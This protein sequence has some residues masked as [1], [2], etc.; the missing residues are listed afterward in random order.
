MEACPRAA[1]HSSRRAAIFCSGALREGNMTRS[2]EPERELDAESLDSWRGI[3]LTTGKSLL[4]LA[5][6][7]IRSFH[8]LPSWD[9]RNPNRIHAVFAR[10]SRALHAWNVTRSKFRHICG[11]HRTRNRHSAKH[12]SNHNVQQRIVCANSVDNRKCI[13]SN[14]Y[15]R[16][17]D[18]KSA[19]RSDTLCLTLLNRFYFMNSTFIALV[20]YTPRSSVTNLLYLPTHSVLCGK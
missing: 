17:R 11:R 12:N 9:N 2:E 16:F 13:T 7:D 8:I 20:V 14:I 19:W 10:S 5:F 18:H 15:C 4:A 1:S 6:A 3:F